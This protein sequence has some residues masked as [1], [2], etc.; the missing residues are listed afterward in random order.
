LT[1]VTTAVYGFLAPY[2][3]LSPRHCDKPLRGDIVIALLASAEAAFLGTPESGTG[4]SKLV[5]FTVEVRNREC[6][7]GSR[8][9]LIQLIGVSLNRDPLAAAS[10]ALQLSNLCGQN[11]T[12]SVQFIPG[13]WLLLIL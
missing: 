4:A 6:A 8:L 5:E 10:E 11:R 9:D 2:T 13:H 7:L 3:E 12:K 1:I